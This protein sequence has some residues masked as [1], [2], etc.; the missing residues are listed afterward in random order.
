MCN[1][2]VIY[3]AKVPVMVTPVRLRITYVRILI[4]RCMWLCS[5][6]RRNSTT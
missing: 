2:H 4:Y 6:L 5:A 3:V 1:V